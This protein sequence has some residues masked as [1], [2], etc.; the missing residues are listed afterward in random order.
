M[1]TKALCIHG[2]FYQPPREDPFSGLIP[3][4]EGAEPFA[5]YNEK[6]AAECYEPNARMDNFSLLSFNF[7]PTLAAWLFSHDG[8]TYHR[9]IE[10]DRRNVAHGGLGNALAQAYNHTILPL[11]HRRDKETQI[12][13]G[14]ADFC[15]RFGHPPKG[16]WLPEMAV[17]YETLE[18]M[19][20]RGIEFT[21]LSPSQAKQSIEPS[22][23]YWVRLPAG[24]RITVF[25]RHED[26][27][28][29][30]AFDPSLTEDASRFVECLDNNADAG[31]YLLATDGETFGHHQPGRERFV[32]N[33]LT[34][35]APR[36][37]F[38]V[39]YLARYLQEHPPT[40]EIEIWE[41]TSWSCWHGIARWNEGCHCTIGDSRWKRLLRRAMD[42]LAWEI[43]A[44]YLAETRGR[45]TAPWQM[46]RDYIHVMLGQTDPHTFISH[47][48]GDSLRTAEEIILLTLL[49]AQ[50][51]RQAMYTSCG[52][53]FEDLSRIEPGLIIAYAAR[54]IQLVEQATGISLER[55]FRQ[56]LE[57]TQSP[58]TG[59]TGTD[60][61]DEV[62]SQNGG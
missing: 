26:L 57:V 30:I 59:Q 22:Q 32:H 10:A 34:Q 48:A 37:G 40:E 53:F 13:W 49:E 5:N 1:S 62:V 23:P 60:I 55:D 21:I 54:A 52:W 42:Q 45:V 61:Y 31:L 14:V 4:E 3:V 16:M 50:R 25:F 20:E 29:R 51:H 33:L 24:R 27:S 19:A 44:I 8:T 46:R 15:H 38:N 2:H 47:Y 28:N 36:R 17:D 12:A 7:G 11:S 58:V 43:D 41:R 9:I 56:G 6:V 18:V 39:T 35:L